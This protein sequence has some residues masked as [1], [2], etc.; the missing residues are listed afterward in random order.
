MERPVTPNQPHA[1]AHPADRVERSAW[2][3]AIESHSAERPEAPAIAEISPEG[4]HVRSITYRGFQELLTSRAAAL[5]GSIGEGGVAAAAL[6]SGIDLAAWLA[7][8]LAAGARLVLLHPG[9]TRR[10]L[11]AA[12]TRTN[13]S[14]VLSCRD[15]TE[16]ERGPAV[17]DR[18]LSDLPSAAVIA[19]DETPGSLVLGSS[20]TTG[21]PKL[22]LRESAALDADA[23]GVADGIGLAAGDSVLCVP[24]ICHSYGVDILLGTLF[25]GAALN[26]MREFSPVAAAAQLA[27][28]ASVLPGIPI[29]YESLARFGRPCAP[30]LRIALSAGSSLSERVRTGFRS[31]WQIEVGQLYG[32][33]ELGTVAIDRPDVPGF[34]PLSI[35][36]PLPGVSFRVLDSERPKASLPIGREGHFAVRSPSMLS[37]YIGEA[38]PTAD[39]HFLTGDLARIDASGRATI[40]GRT[41]LL[42]DVGGFKVNPLEV[43]AALR[44]HP[45]VGD[46]AAGPLALSDTVQRVR[47][48]IEPADA[49]DPPDPRELRAFLRDR[50]SAHKIPRQFHLVGSLP[51]SPLGKVLRD[52]LQE[53]GC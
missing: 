51:R 25:A 34:A 28:G 10:E 32:A 17:P 35:G 43:E 39:G 29:L 5:V 36:R 4:R 47:V 18:S 38:V 27:A 40:T 15:V 45:G 24:P 6:P 53:S 50:L 14:A 49:A 23:V 42:I 3:R 9:C 2:L 52:R 22:V 8:S 11:H 7:A 48:W 26:V 13:A 19:N 31:K 12:A 21:L 20:G 44:E 37:A 30:R 46:C 1:R 33:T 41:K 16:L